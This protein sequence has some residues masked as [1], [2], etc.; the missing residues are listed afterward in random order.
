MAD[1]QPILDRP[2]FFFQDASHSVTEAYRELLLDHAPHHYRRPARLMEELIAEQRRAYAAADTVFTFSRWFARWLVE[3]DGVPAERVLVI[4]GGLNAPP[5][6]TRPDDLGAPG[7]GRPTRVLFVGRE[8]RRKGGDLVV[9][10]IEQ[11]RS[12][13]SGDF[14]LTIVGPAAWPL[15][16]PPPDWIDFR[17]EMPAA[18]LG[19]L[20]ACHD[21]FAM[22]SW[23]EP[24]GLAP[25]EAR[26]AGVPCLV[27]DAFCMPEVV[28]PRAGRLIPADG[29]P[30][31]IAEQLY[32]LS[33]DDDVYARVAADRAGVFAEN[34]WSRVA[35]R[36]MPRVS[37]VLARA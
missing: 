37:D 21:V 32:A 15:P 27:R 12:S 34:N 23:F 29:G 20:W 3:H 7:P 28:P 19:P 26:A 4:G 25:L 2:T 36:A 9:A 24:Y 33:R 17:G 5:T 16:T 14:T 35:E 30:D 11:L 31:E 10:A 22:P 8:F 6:R 1:V 13:G 18:Q